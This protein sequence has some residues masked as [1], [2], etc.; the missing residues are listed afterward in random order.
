MN[1]AVDPEP[2]PALRRTRRCDL[3]SKQFRTKEQIEEVKLQ[4]SVWKVTFLDKQGY[5]RQVDVDKFNDGEYAGVWTG[6]EVRCELD[7]HEYTLH[8][9]NEMRTEAYPCLV[10]IDNFAIK[11]ISKKASDE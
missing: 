8:T 4:S 6:Y 1:Q 5:R 3:C 10:I 11:I 2:L 7:G 9:R